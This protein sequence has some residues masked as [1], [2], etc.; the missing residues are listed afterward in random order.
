MSAYV[1]AVVVLPGWRSKQWKNKN[2]RI[3]T[4]CMVIPKSLH[5]CRPQSRARCVISEY[6]AGLR[7]VK[8]LASTPDVIAIPIVPRTSYR[9]S[10]SVRDTW[11]GRTHT[12][13]MHNAD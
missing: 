11:D 8:R 9:R 7:G 12:R 4:S 3:D 1:G 2:I 13:S 5:Q 6:P 10:K